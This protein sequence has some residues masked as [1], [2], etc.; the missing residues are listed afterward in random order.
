ML[1]KT[2]LH[3]LDI[4][5]RELLVSIQERRAGLVSVNCV[6]EMR[7]FLLKMHD[8]CTNISDPEFIATLRSRIIF[9]CRLKEWEM[10]AEI[11]GNTKCLTLC[12]MNTFTLQSISCNLNLKN[13]DVSDYN[14]SLTNFFHIIENNTV[15]DRT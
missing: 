13:L 7:R 14:Q 6:R 2:S 8:S 9:E 3:A 1:Q 5:I 15:M 12:S 10:Y 4:K 11:D